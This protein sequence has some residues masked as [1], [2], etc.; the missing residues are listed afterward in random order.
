M[1]SIESVSGRLEGAAA[2]D[3]CLCL[4]AHRDDPLFVRDT[5][6]LRRIVEVEM[7]RGVMLR[8]CRDALEP[9]TPQAGRKAPARD[10]DGRSRC[11][12][13]WLLA[14]TVED[15]E[16]IFPLQTSAR[17]QVNGGQ[18]EKGDKIEAPQN[19]CQARPITNRGSLI[20]RAPIAPR[21]PGS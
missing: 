10:T 12:A 4:T 5:L 3:D 20:G 13:F 19:Y 9:A 6:Y 7:D 18:R 11:R 14:L 17:S 2:V 1:A 21:S 8:F 15:P 16:S